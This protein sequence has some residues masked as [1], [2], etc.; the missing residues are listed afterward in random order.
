VEHTAATA[1][2]AKQA[3]QNSARRQV[4]IRVMSR[5]AD[6]SLIEALAADMSDARLLNM[7]GTSSIANERTSAT[8]YSALI[9]VTFDRAAVERW[10]RDNNVPNYMRAADDAGPRTQV[11][12]RITGGLR[13]W[14][15]LNRDLREAGVWAD[16][17]IKLTSIWGPNISATIAGT[18]RSMFITE[19][20]RLG[21]NV[22]EVDGIIRA[23]R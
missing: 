10:L 12:F 19:M 4:F 11:F 6:R 15:A 1:A 17:D 9:T 2:A 8:A 7:V 20:R 14:A 22:S 21:W 18:R 5:Y 3:A 16:L 23:Q 13:E